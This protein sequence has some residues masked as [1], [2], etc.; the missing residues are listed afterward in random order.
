MR[1]FRMHFSI[2]IAMFRPRKGVVNI[3]EVKILEI[4]LV[5]VAIL[6]AHDAFC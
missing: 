2:D 6:E 5:I 3:Q 4:Y 1:I